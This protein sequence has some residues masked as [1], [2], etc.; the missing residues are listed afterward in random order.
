MPYLRS[1]YLSEKED[2]EIHHDLCRIQAEINGV[3]RGTSSS[4][5]ESIK[6]EGEC[7]EYIQ[8]KSPYCKHSA[9]RN[10]QTIPTWLEDKHNAVCRNWTTS[11]WMASWGE[12]GAPVDERGSLCRFC[13]ATSIGFHLPGGRQ[14]L[15]S[16]N[17]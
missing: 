12:R 4:D 10:K 5:P 2:K 9:Q 6:N 15:M 11:F 14:T 13:A 7:N 16:K 3:Q 17:R 1:V 8:S